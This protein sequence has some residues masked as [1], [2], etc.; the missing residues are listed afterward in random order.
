MSL[1]ANS[2]ENCGKDIVVL[3][4]SVQDQIELDRNRFYKFLEALRDE[5]VTMPLKVSFDTIIDQAL[6]NS[7]FFLIKIG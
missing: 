5:S 2:I 3:I 7:A 1:I 6:E 4:G